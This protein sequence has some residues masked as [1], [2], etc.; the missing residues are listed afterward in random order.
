MLCKFLLCTQSTTLS[1]YRSCT[2]HKQASFAAA[3]DTVKKENGRWFGK[4]E[5]DLICSWRLYFRPRSGPARSSA[6][7]SRTEQR[8]TFTWPETARELARSNIKS[9]GPQR[10]QLVSRL[11]QMTGHPRS[12]CRRFIQR[13]ANNARSRYKKWP[14]TEQERLLELLDKNS[15]GDAARLL[16]RSCRSIY[17]VLRRLKIGASMR[18]DVFSKR[19]LAAVLHVRF[20]AVDSWIQKGWLK[21]KVIQIGQLKR[22]VIK[23]DDFV[24]FCLEYREVIIG[25]RLNLERLEFVYKYVFPPDHNYLLSVR[26]SKK[27]REAFDLSHSGSAE[28]DAELSWEPDEK[29]ANATIGNSIAPETTDLK[30]D[31]D[32]VASQGQ[33]HLQVRNST[34]DWRS[35]HKP[36]QLRIVD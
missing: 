8:R 14:P 26:A 24:Q 12:A 36:S 30:R 21:A 35:S 9:E 11:S 2:A 25:N 19:R 6:R 20:C 34:D 13:M 16:R 3:H 4:I 22:T 31:A 28:E 33:S 15:V 1:L 18:Q 7:Q 17:A 5:R 32:L 29:G 23:P 27:E 10:Q